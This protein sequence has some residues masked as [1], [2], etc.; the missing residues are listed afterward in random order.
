M[1]CGTVAKT[2]KA[3]VRSAKFL[4]AVASGKWVLTESWLQE[5][6][7]RRARAEEEAFEVSGDKKSPVPSAPTRSRL[8][9]AEVVSA[10]QEK[11]LMRPVL[12]VAKN[13][14]CRAV[15]LYVCIGVL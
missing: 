4:R 5:C 14:R 3:K 2:T 11:E 6:K 8:A 10:R 13:L 9:H 12:F 15:M 7:R 1:V